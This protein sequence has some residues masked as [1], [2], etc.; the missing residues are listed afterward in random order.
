M[1]MMCSHTRQQQKKPHA[2]AA[3]AATA[4]A[5]VTE[6]ARSIAATVLLFT[7][8]Q[9]IHADF[10]DVQNVENKKFGLFTIL[11]ANCQY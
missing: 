6:T 9:T 3:T 1:S 2:F 10:I 8:N 4:T 5:A 11:L 7:I